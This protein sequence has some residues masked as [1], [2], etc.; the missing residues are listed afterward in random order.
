LKG[1]TEEKRLSQTVNARRD[2]FN[3][4]NILFH[5]LAIY[6]NLL[7]TWHTRIWLGFN[8]VAASEWYYCV[9]RPSE[10][11]L[12]GVKQVLYD[13]W[14]GEDALKSEEY[15]PLKTLTA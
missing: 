10:W 12:A 13:W 9:C 4:M 14:G 3:H 2:S 15:Q 8:E 1:A 5:F 7:N 11:E 6:D